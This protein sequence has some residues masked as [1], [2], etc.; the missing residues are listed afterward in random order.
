MAAVSQRKC[1]TRSFF[2]GLILL[3]CALTFYYFTVLRIDYAKTSLLDLP[4]SPD[5]PEYFA[6]A[7]TLLKDGWPSIRIGYDKLPP[8]FPSGYPAVML[9]WLKILPAADSILAPFRTNQTLGLF[10]LLAIFGFY[11]SL[12][13]ALPTCMRYLHIACYCSCGQP[14]VSTA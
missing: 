10:L 6:Q 2:A 4:P 7:K 13:S 3:F 12:A 1:T 9:P 8:R 5:A 14:R 11:T